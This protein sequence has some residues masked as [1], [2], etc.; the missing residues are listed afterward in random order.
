[1]DCKAV[2]EKLSA[3]LDGQ[4]SAEE[5]R[6]VDAHLKTCPACQDELSSLEGT[7]ALLHSLEAVAPPV[8]LKE[9][10]LGRV[11][12]LNLRQQPQFTVP[13][14]G[15][16]SQVLHR[17]GRSRLTGVAV[18][19][20]VLLLAVLLGRGP[21]QDGYGLRSLKSPLGSQPKLAEQEVAQGPA[22]ATPNAASG[23]AEQKAAA[24]AP[25]LMMAEQAVPGEARKQAYAPAALGRKVIQTGR[26]VLRV[27][28]LDTAADRLQELV[29]KQGGFV[30]GSNL[31]RGDSTRAAS[32]TL[33]V[34][35]PAFTAVLKQA[36]E[37]GEVEQRELGG[38]DVTEE[39]VDVEARQRNLQRQEERFLDILSRAKTVDEVLKVETQLERVRGEIESLTARLKYLDN[40]VSLSTL[41]VDLVERAQPVSIVRTFQWSTLGVRLRQAVV[42]SM[43]AIFDYV[44]QGLVYVAAAVPFLLVGLIV[45]AV[46]WWLERRRRSK[47]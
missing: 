29:T 24:G 46:A 7:I 26:L 3:Y 1:M 10:I 36:E 40:Q 22:P 9:K 45:A 17:L 38:K 21:L 37:L 12:E 39:Y 25:R 28:N 42:G 32:Y 19:A 30:Q 23:A 18:A 8:E 6:L 33:R 11:Q 41:S 2:E 44:G 13:G 16:F 14:R 43:N 34:P 5:M 47:R 4:L 15:F 31:R 35:A 27:E 20:V